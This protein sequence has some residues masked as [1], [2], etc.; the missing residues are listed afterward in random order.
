MLVVGAAINP[1]HIPFGQIYA[2]KLRS[3]C[4]GNNIMCCCSSSHSLRSAKLNAIPK[5]TLHTTNT[6]YTHYPP[7]SFR[8]LPALIW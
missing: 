2:D 3:E 8:W 1:M 6:T 7:H 5:L 4:N